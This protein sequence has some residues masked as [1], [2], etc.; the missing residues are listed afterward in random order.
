MK[1][2]SIIIG[3][4][5]TGLY[6]LDNLINKLNIKDICL[7]EK[8]Y[9]IGGKVD[10][11]YHDNKVLYEKGPW[12]LHESQNKII[13][14][15]KNLNIDYNQC[16]SCKKNSKQ[17]TYDICN[18]RKI[19][20]KK[21]FINKSGYSYKDRLIL[22]K[23]KCKAG[24]LDKF[25]K[26]PLKMDSTSKPRDKHLKY[27]GKYFSIDKGFSEIINKLA[28]E[29]KD[30]IHTNSK[31]LNVCRTKYKNE[32]KYKLT[33]QNRNKNKYK[34]FNVYC[35]HLFICVPPEYTLNW[36]IVKNYLLPLV[37]SVGTI[38]LNHIYAYSDDIKKIYN[39]EFNIY[40]DSELSQIISGN[41]DN[42]WFQI[43]Y[44]SGENANF[45]NRLK[46]QE[47]A[48]FKKHLKKC[49]YEIFDKKEI[50]IKQIKSHYMYNAIHYWK[51]SFNFDVKK[52]MKNSIYPHP[53]KLPNLYWSGE[54]F[55]T[56]QGWI[57]GC[58]ETADLALKVFKKNITN[59][60]LIKTLNLNKFQHYVILDNRFI[61]VSK[62]KNVHPGSK[63]AIVNHNKEDISQ[64][65]R[66]IHESSYSWNVLYN[67]QKY[68]IKDNKLIEFKY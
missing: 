37:N 8:S 65:F 42:N 31:I 15:L 38:E 20:F 6:I 48:L 60:L 17:I 19:S 26:L 47:P 23:K 62:W 53:I 66:Q 67:L 29:N 7:F 3:G 30:Y 61:D 1:Y 52:N 40:T 12:R 36:S 63:A 35:N 44:T 41:Y 57:E 55:S 11:Q 45:W 33:I 21:K 58:L 14:L 34:I 25:Y 64:L 51:P 10:T 54:A 22:S 49:F 4:G 39:N 18:K 32:Y 27:S 59:K 13:K 9:R 28:N 68:W 43:S 16:S 46:I 24:Y 2:K 5:I 50:N 56:V